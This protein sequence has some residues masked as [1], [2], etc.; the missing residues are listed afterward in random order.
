MRREHGA[1]LAYVG[2]ILL[3]GYVIASAWALPAGAGMMPIFAAAGVL[4]FSL[5]QIFR[6]LTRPEAE[7]AG[8]RYL[9]LDR[10]VL[11]PIVVTIAT[12][13]YVPLIVGLGY[14]AATAVYLVAVTL[15]L[16][17]RSWRAIVLAAMLLL[18]LMYAFFVGFLDANLPEGIAI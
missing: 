18:P 6:V 12:A 10:D 15:F 3:S 9:E 16:G 2:F 7:P 5:F 14:F 11:R 1:I 4:L 17:V 8:G 13:A